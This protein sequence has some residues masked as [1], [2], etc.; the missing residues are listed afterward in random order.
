[1][2]WLLSR[3]SDLF[4]EVV[5]GGL[6]PLRRPDPSATDFPNLRRSSRTPGVEIGVEGGPEFA[7]AA[8]I[9]LLGA[10][11]LM[12]PVA[13]VYLLTKQRGATTNRW[14]SPC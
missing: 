1:M 6:D 11:A 8:V 14:F 5:F 12:I 13:W 4:Y 2:A 9:S 3:W 10:L 7:V